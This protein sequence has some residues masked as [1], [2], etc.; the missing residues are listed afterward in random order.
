MQ[1]CVFGLLFCASDLFFGLREVAPK[2]QKKALKNLDLRSSSQKRQKQNA[3]SE[4]META[5]DT[6]TT[7]IVSTSKYIFKTCWQHLMHGNSGYSVHIEQKKTYLSMLAYMLKKNGASISE[8]FV[9][10]VFLKLQDSWD[11]VVDAIRSREDFESALADLKKAIPYPS[12]NVVLKGALHTTL[13]VIT[14]TNRVAGKESTFISDAADQIIKKLDVK[15]MD[16][17]AYSTQVA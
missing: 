13:Q 4:Y 12:E 9:L 5:T 1:D 8:V 2:A 16:N 7:I 11:T 10:T 17:E 14:S 6:I 15:L 3:S